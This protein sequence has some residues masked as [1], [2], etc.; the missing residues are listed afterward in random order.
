M[1]TRF[2]DQ[3]LA[4]DGKGN[5]VVWGPSWL[6]GPKEKEQIKIKK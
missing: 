3:P 6:L 4:R 2:G 5:A 1:R